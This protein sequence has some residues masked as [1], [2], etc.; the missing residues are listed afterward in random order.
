MIT[1]I[2]IKNLGNSIQFII[3]STNDFFE[4]EKK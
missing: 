3:A 1:K 4:P 2:D